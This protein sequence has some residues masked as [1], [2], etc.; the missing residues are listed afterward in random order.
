MHLPEVIPLF[1]L[2]N[3][4]F[5]PRMPLPLH[6]FEPRYRAMTRDAW[7]GARLIGMVLLR[8][9]WQLDYEGRPPIFSRGTV[10]EIVRLEELTDGRFNVVLRGL[11]EFSIVREVD[12]DTPYRRAAV[13]W[14]EVGS[15]PLPAGMRSQVIGCVRRYLAAVGR[16]VSDDELTRGA[17]DDET[18]VNFFA[19]HLDLPPVEKQVLLEVDTL[20]E[21]GRRLVDVLD[22][23]IEEARVHGSGPSRAH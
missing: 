20:A 23:R 13:T 7:R 9:D 14:H 10:G 2:P 18:F 1:P 12:R 11:R 3:V 21:R 4:V 17:V 19:Q 8:G 15:C 22:F 5:F 16:E 6:I